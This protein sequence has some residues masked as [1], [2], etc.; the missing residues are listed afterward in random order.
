MSCMRDL[1]RWRRGNFR[2]S[3]KYW[4]IKMILK[5]NIFALNAIIGTQKNKIVTQL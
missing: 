4:L 1:R 3:K 2:R 5:V